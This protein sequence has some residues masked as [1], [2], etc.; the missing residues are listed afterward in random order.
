MLASIGMDCC[1]PGIIQSLMRLLPAPAFL[2]LFAVS[3]VAH[4]ASLPA[5]RQIEIPYQG[6]TLHA[7]LYKPDGDG[8]FPTMIALH[9][10]GGLTGQIR[11]RPSSMRAGSVLD[12]SKP[13]AKS[14][15]LVASLKSAT[16]I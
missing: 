12:I 13:R 9:A 5:P 15:L 1:L 2:M 7:Q 4:A 16:G 3:S 11:K 14:W 10:C 8:P 6:G